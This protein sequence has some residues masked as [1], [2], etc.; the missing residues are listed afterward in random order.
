[1]GCP[2]IK[3]YIDYVYTNKYFIAQF[4]KTYQYDM[5]MLNTLICK[6]LAPRSLLAIPLVDSKRQ[7]IR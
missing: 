3:K 2:A 4:G 1:M 5:L 7:L 6:S